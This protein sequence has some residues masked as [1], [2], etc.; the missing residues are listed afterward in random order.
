[1]RSPAGRIASCASCA[2]F[3]LLRYV[4]RLGR[5]GT[6]RRTCS[7]ICVARRVD[8]LLRQVRAVGAH[9]G[10]VARA[11]RAAARRHRAGR[12]EA[13][14][15][16]RLLLQRRRGERRLRPL[17][18]R[19]ATRPTRRV[20]GRSSRRS[21]S[22]ARAR[23]V[24]QHDVGVGRERAGVGVEVAARRE[25]L[26]V[27][28]RRASRGN[29]GA[30]R[31]RTC[32]RGPSTTPLRNAMRAR[33]RSTT[34]RVGDALHPAG[35]A[36]PPARCGGTR[37][38]TPRSRRGGRGRAGPPAP[39][40][41]S[42]R[43]RASCRCASWIAS[44]R[45]LVEHH[46]LHRHLRLQH[47]EHVPR[48]RL[49][50]A[51]LVGREVELARRPSAPPSARRRPASCR[52]ARRRPASKWSSTSMPSRRTSGLVTLFGAL[53]GAAG[54]VADVADARHHRVAVRAEE[55]LDG[56]RLRAGL[57][58]HERFGHVLFLRVLRRLAVGCEPS[59]VVGGRG[60]G[61]YR[62]RTVVP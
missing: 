4:A 43:G 27:E 22:A 62:R 33:S 3:T 6:P 17:G 39:R 32:P 15:A 20:N 23:L 12:A 42:C 34:S 46:P 21:A 5:A 45:D 10:D 47:L 55:A 16:A 40:P 41:A 1:M 59:S 19:L 24:E 8:R 53:L 60:R 14:L 50:L 9:V 18:E 28:R 49:A 11:R 7:R 52:R 31:A 57:H 61:A 48:D 54:Q 26:A 13:E 25:A 36:C 44:L 2:F 30:R 29:V 56:L 58:D 51:V 37:R 38:S 35:R